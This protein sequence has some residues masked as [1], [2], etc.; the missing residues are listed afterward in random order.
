MDTLPL[1]P[2][3]PKNEGFKPPNIYIYIYIGYKCYNP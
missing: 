2:K 1:D 3:T